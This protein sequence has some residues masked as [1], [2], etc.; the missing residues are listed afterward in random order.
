MTLIEKLNSL[1]PTLVAE[2]LSE[3]AIQNGFTITKDFDC[4]VD[5]WV[6]D[7]I[8]TEEI[9][10]EG[11]IRISYN[12][13]GQ[14]YFIDNGHI[15]CKVSETNLWAIIWQEECHI[16]GDYEWKQEIQ[17][18]K[19]W[20]ENYPENVDT[21]VHHAFINGVLY[22]PKSIVAYKGKS[23][24]AY[25]KSLLP[26]LKYSPTTPPDD[27]IVVAGKQVKLYNADEKGW[28]II[29]NYDELPEWVE[30]CQEHKHLF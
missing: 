19:E 6:T 26:L 14:L 9:T 4:L 15:V 24:K 28:H 18:A 7:K 27:T 22:F 16:E 30:A 25:P 11:F 20:V 10:D 2:G 13:N 3:L 8:V 5:G 23:N 1:N 29:T 17:Y 12:L 21:D